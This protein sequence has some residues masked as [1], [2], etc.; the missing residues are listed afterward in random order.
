MLAT[1]V[2]E[3]VDP[4]PTAFTPSSTLVRPQHAALALWAA[5][6]TQPTIAPESS[7]RHVSPPDFS[8]TLPRETESIRTA[9]IV[10]SHVVQIRYDDATADGRKPHIAKAKPSRTESLFSDRQTLRMEDHEI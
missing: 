3:P 4:A 7:T 1:F 6:P 9:S 2:T 8:R 5:T 10:E